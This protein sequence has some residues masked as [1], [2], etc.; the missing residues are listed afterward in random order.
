M[1]PFKP[2]VDPLGQHSRLYRYI[3]NS[4][5]WLCL[6][7][8]DQRVYIALLYYLNSF[9]NGDLS[10][11][12]TT[13]KHHGIGSKATLAKNLRALQA[14][15]LIA[16]TRKGGATRNGQ[17]LPS[18]Y[19]FT[20]REVFANPSKFIDPSKPTNDYLKVKS[21]AIGRA[22]IREAEQSSASDL[23]KSEGQ[24]LDPI[25]SKNSSLRLVIS[26]QTEQRVSRPDQKLNLA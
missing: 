21:I 17:R 9:N 19:R 10:F 11:A 12:M 18:L 7:A 4:P 1:K 13:A 24:N 2:P 5:A 16:R 15:G 25:G 3:Q 14:V 6:S 23:T 22:L 8:S 20:D 26:S